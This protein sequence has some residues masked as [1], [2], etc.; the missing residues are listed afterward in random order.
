MG[1]QQHWSTTPAQNATA[2][3]AVNWREG[4]SPSTVNDSA[5]QMMARFKAFVADTAGSLVTGGTST[6]FTVTTNEVFTALVDGLAVTVRMHAAN[7]ATPTFAPDGLAAKAI[8]VLSGTAVPAGALLAGSLQTFTYNSSADAWIVRGAIG[9]TRFV[10]EVFDWAGED[11][12]PGCLFCDGAAV[13]RSTYAALFAVIGTTYGAGDEST[14]FNVPDLR[15]RVTAGRDDMG[16]AAAGRLTDDATGIDGEV[17]GDA[18]GVQEHT[19]TIAQL[20]AHSHDGTTD[21]QG[22]HT[23]AAGAGNGYVHIGSDS[24]GVI[25]IG[26]GGTDVGSASATAADGA[27]GHSVGTEN[28]GGDEPHL[29]VQPTLVLNKCIFAGV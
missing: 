14:T 2:D 8:Q 19:L 9:T 3:S 17:L 10:G 22:Q 7:G 12:R 28:V 21:V 20:P 25:D 1:L 24:M 29:N 18:G 26:D 27:H 6:A 15:G 5:R 4:Q 13:S 11:P 23:H 16:G